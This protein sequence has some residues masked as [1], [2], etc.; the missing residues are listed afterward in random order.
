MK[1]YLF[2]VEFVELVV[3][4]YLCLRAVCAEELDEFVGDDTDTAEV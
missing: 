3:I 4:E 1:L 2:R